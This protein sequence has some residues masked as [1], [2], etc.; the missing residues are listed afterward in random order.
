MMGKIQIEMRGQT[1]VC[2]FVWRVGSGTRQDVGFFIKHVLELT[3]T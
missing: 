2:H 1:L 3:T